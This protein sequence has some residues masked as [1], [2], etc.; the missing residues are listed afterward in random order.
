MEFRIFEKEHSLQ[1][2]DRFYYLYKETMDTVNA[3]PYY[4]FS[5]DYFKELLSGLS[6]NSMIA[7]VFFE[8]KMTSAAL[9][10]YKDGYLHYHLG[11]SDKE[12][13][14]LG[15][16]IFQFHHIALW[17]KDH[18]IHTFHL[19]GGYTS[20][21]SL[22][23]FKH[24]FNQERTLEFYIGRK[25]HNPEKYHLLVSSWERYYEQKMTGNFFPA[26]RNKSSEDVTIKNL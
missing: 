2:I 4:Y 14:N 20:R 7:A 15:T 9:C 18:G 25:V 8:G 12:F 10:M 23:Q 1:I 22:F 24:R 13:L 21:D 26:Y 19:G 11:C 3:S 5:R 6:G 16:N 17:G